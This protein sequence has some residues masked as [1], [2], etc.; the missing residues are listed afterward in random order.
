[1]CVG[2]KTE[3]SYKTE[4]QD[5]DQHVCGCQN[6]GVVHN[7]RP[8]VDTNTYILWVEC[9]TRPRQQS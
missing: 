7:T 2:A 3:G 8:S 5:P 4:G 1:M 9:A 6:R